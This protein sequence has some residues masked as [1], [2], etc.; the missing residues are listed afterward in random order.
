MH[1]ICRNPPSDYRNCLMSLI[2]GFCLS[3]PSG[4]I[5][6]CTRPVMYIAMMGWCLRIA[7]DTA[8]Y[9]SV[10][11]VLHVEV[12]GRMELTKATTEFH[13]WQMAFSGCQLV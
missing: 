1:I 9:R 10:V 4:A 6:E 8:T 3:V 11:W 13:K 12:S 2:I 5:C 7:T